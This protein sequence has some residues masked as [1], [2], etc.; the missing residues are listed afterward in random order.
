MGSGNL[1]VLLLVLAACGGSSGKPDA[2]IDARLEGFTEPDIYCPGGPKCASAGDGVLK[3]G[4]AKRNYT[5]QNFETYTDEN[6][7]REW[8]SNEPYTDLNGNGKFDGVWLF[9]G[10][11]AAISVKTEVEARA[12]AFV[13]GD[14]TVVIMYID[15]VGLILGDLD[16]IRQHPTLAGVDVDHIIIGATHAHDTPDTL[17]L[18]GPT[19]TV[20]GRQKFVLEVLYAQAAAA[21]KQAIETAQP[22]QL[23]IAST[24]MINDE[25]NPLSKTDDF[26]KDIRDPVIFDPTLTIARFVK[27]SN[28]S[29][30]IGT[31][32]NWANHP[33]ASHFS[34]TDGSE[35]T[36]HYPHWLRNGVEQGVTAAQSKYAATNLDGIGGVT[37]FVNGALGGQIGSLR[38]THPPGPGGVP[39][40]QVSHAMEEALGNNAAAKALT[41]LADRGESF[42][43]LPLS[44]KSAVYNARIENTYF[45]VAF[46]IELLGPHPLVGY[47]PDDPI[48]AGNYPWMPL[49]TTYL[50][51]GPLGVITAPGELHPELWVGGYDGSWS[52]G[53]PM[54]DMTKP[55]LPN[56]E[57]APKPPY[58]RDLVLAH[59]GV[60]FP[61]LAGMAEDYVGYIIPAY[62][63]VLD[64]A[65][66][67]IVEAEGDH[68]EEVYSLGPLGEQHTVHPILQL[69]QYRR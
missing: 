9:G 65:D 34:D 43:N 69:L 18:W 55:N 40:T 5:P 27:S 47:N 52:W 37:V 44:V 10:G 68:Y 25:S 62:N 61:I 54:L 31:L 63:Y 39:V 67:Y 14:T 8:Q 6:G 29:E 4:A 19:A 12:L 51:V 20:T 64:P 60:K 53:W 24:K 30:T 41:A 36:A 22:A 17:G 58:M 35:I 3:V 45:H 49:R 32:V 42:T 21:A 16:A 1:K 33:E 59:T 2:G 38:G 23:V 7:D 28:P 50:Q 56:F 57:A 26:N 66:P 48:D 11:R 15:S 13:Q 46:L